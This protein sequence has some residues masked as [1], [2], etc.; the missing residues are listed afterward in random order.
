LSIALTR[1]EADR[2]VAPPKWR[3]H[4]RRAKTASAFSGTGFH[5]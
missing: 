5:E 4:R 1:P 2:L 3:L